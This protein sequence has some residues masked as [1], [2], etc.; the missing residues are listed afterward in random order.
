MSKLTNRLSS[1]ARKLPGKQRGAMTMFSAVL[2]LILLTELVL[3]ATQVGVFEQRKS[4]NDLRQ[5]QAFH[6]A[7]S[8]LQNAR[9]FFLAN[10]NLLS[11]PGE[12]GWLDTSGTSQRWTAC[13]EADFDNANHPCSGEAFPEGAAQR[14]SIE[15]GTYYYNFDDPL[16]PQVDDTLLPLLTGADDPD[17]VD[18]L[19][20]LGERVEVQAL[21]CVL[22][23]NR[24]AV[25]PVPAVEGCV[26]HGA[27]VEGEHIYFML[28]L[29]AKGQ[30]ACANP[31][32]PATCEAE[33]LIAEKLGSFGPAAGNGGPG[34]PLTSRTSVPAGGTVELVPNPNGGGPGVPI[35]GWVNGRVDDLCPGDDAPWDPS[36]G[37]WSTCER[38][39]WYGVDQMPDDYACPT[40]SCSCGTDERRLSYAEGGE[41]IV[42]IDIVVDPMFPC[43]LFKSTFGMEKS[44]AN[45]NELKASVGVEI[46]DCSILD[47]NSVGVYWMTGDTCNIASGKVIGS[48][49]FPV[50]LVSAAQSTRLNGGASLFGVLFVTDVLHPGATFDSTGNNTVY[51]AV[52][53]DAE[54]DNFS[55]T[56][57]IVYVDAIAQLASQSGGI[58]KVSGGW[59]DFHP[60][61]QGRA[62]S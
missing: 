30:A 50:F 13:E 41:Q 22:D 20:Q 40:A 59:T 17:I 31:T 7:E 37:S 46:D 5:K 24:N 4:A 60:V 58:G 32:D 16:N 25:S 23:I 55:G 28:T 8:G 49:E 34:V 56:F 12:N 44:A 11:Y 10:V 9:E 18:R 2:I 29:L 3:Y 39:E 35:S 15:A 33:A 45:F 27:A 26:P 42:G 47:E 54:V 48:A 1:R 38:H 51:G 53:V 52:T 19:A 43:D 57:Q 21:L 61:W 6:A 36:S 14:A 62:E